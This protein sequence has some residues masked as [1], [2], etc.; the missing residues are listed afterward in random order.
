MILYP[1]LQGR[2]VAALQDIARRECGADVTSDNPDYLRWRIRRCRR[3]Q[4]LNTTIQDRRPQTRVPFYM[5]AEDL[6][7]IDTLVAAHGYASRQHFLHAA[8]AHFLRA[9]SDAT[10]GPL[11]DRI[12]KHL[13][14]RRA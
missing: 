13:P 7:G 12:E 10:S 9:H 4:R 5:A 2:T 8:V 6:A 11:A 3:G 1:D 14:V